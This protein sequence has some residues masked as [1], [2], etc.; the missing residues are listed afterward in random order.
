[1]EE[2]SGDVAGVL[3]RLLDMDAEKSES[4]AERKEAFDEAL[5]MDLMS[6]AF[7]AWTLVVERNS[8]GKEI[9]E[10]SIVPVRYLKEASEGVVTAS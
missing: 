4:S 8:V 6:G 10:R 3:R 2:V 1:M 9:L 7:N 5:E